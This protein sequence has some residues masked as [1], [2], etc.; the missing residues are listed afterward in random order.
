MAFTDRRSRVLVVA[1]AVLAS[2]GSFV[3]AQT[4][5]ITD[6]HGHVQYTDRIPPEAVN[7][8]MVELNKQGQPKKVT[9]PAMTPEQRKVWEA[10]EEALAVDTKYNRIKLQFRELKSQVARD[11]QLVKKQ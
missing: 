9:E 1:A 10:N 2:A 6:E 4:Y 8:G 3:A 7:R 5:K 11:T